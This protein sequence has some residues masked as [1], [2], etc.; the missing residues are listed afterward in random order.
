LVELGDQ[1]GDV[2]GEFPVRRVLGELDEHGHD[3]A[4]PF[5]DA[6]VRLHSADLERGVDRDVPGVQRVTDLRVRREQ[7][8]E[9]AMCT[10][11]AVGTVDR[12]RR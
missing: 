1:A 5:T 9:P 2:I 10:G 12:A 11:G 4:E 7:A 3:D 6:G 8:G